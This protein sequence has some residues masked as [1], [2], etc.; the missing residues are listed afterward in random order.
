VPTMEG[1]Y[2]IKNLIIISA[3]LVIGETVRERR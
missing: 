3:A 1:Q 2:V